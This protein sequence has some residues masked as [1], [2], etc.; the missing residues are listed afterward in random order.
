MVPQSARSA[1]LHT[2]TAGPPVQGVLRDWDHDSVLPCHPHQQL[3]HVVDLEACKQGMQWARD[4][5]KGPEGVI[6]M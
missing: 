2:V 6:G 5:C 1:V 3:H 4:Q